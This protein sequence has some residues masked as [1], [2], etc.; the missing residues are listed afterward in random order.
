MANK[1][2]QAPALGIQQRG[3]MTKHLVAL[4]VLAALAGCAGSPGQVACLMVKGKDADCLRK[5]SVAGD[6]STIRDA[7]TAEQAGDHT[8]ALRIYQMHAERGD[9]KAMVSVGLKHYL[10]QGTPQDYCAAMDWFL[11]A[12]EQGDADAYVN[13]GVM[14]RDGQCVPVNRKIAYA[15]FLTIHMT[16]LGGEST[17]MRANKNLRREVAEL[18]KE[19]IQEA[20]CYTPAYVRL[21]ARSKGQLAEVPTDVLPSATTIRI[22]DN[23]W[24]SE[25][26]KKG[27]SFSCPAPWA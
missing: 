18:P 12:F 6:N 11:K 9:S 13:I 2:L 4:F 8:T 14:H 17:Q 19:N 16:S 15:L 20:L 21:Y 3:I 5:K 1:A 23:N 10:G 26:E 27:H 7:I 22:K 24:W 25:E